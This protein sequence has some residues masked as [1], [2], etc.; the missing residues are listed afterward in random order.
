MPSTQP[1]FGLSQIGQIAIPVSDLNRAVE[2]YRYTLGM[3]FLFRAPNLAFFDCGGIRLML[4]GPEK[5]QFDPPPSIIYYKVEDIQHAYTSLL[6][7]QVKFEGPPH[8]VA[9]LPEQDVW[10]AFFR[11]QDQHLLAL[12]SQINTA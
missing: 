5:R 3:T 12:M 6:A 1:V 4:T 7:R 8:C 11:D 2:F 10:M 9:K